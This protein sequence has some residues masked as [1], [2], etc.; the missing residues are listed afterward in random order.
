LKD[1][2][3]SKIKTL[4]KGPRKKK[5]KIKRIRTKMKKKYMRNCN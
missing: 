3:E 5:L 1:E 4:A 2:I